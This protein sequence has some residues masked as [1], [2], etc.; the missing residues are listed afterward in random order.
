MNAVL[1]SVFAVLALELLAL[2]PAQQDA[3]AP[4][5]GAEWQVIQRDKR[6]SFETR[7]VWLNNLTRA[8]G[9]MMTV[10]SLNPIVAIAEEADE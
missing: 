8:V 7:L 9:R 4:T 3:L 1:D 10:P 5:L 6:E 2:F